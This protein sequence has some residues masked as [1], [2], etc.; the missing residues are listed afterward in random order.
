MDI[1]RGLGVAAETEA[2]GV[3]LEEHDLVDPLVDPLSDLDGEAVQMSGGGRKASVKALAAQGAEGSAGSLPHANVIREAFG[4]HDL[5]GV[6]AHTGPQA[7]AATE[8]MGA[9]AYAKGQDIVFGAG[10]TSLFTAAHEATHVVQQRAGIKPPGGV[11][12]PGD[13]LEQQANAVAE[14]VVSGESAVQMLDAITG[15]R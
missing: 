1:S 10:G 8:A 13:P 9:R 14:L 4:H 3:V 5:G 7:Q 11:G 2:E 15:R 6:R 12:S